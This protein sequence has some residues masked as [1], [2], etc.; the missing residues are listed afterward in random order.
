[1][2]LHTDCIYFFS[3]FQVQEWKNVSNCPC[4]YK[5]RN[6]CRSFILKWPSAL[7]KCKWQM[8]YVMKNTLIKRSNN[9]QSIHCKQGDFTILKELKYLC[10]SR[11]PVPC[12]SV[13]SPWHCPL[14]R[15]RRKPKIPPVRWP[16]GWTTQFTRAYSHFLSFSSVSGET[17]REKWLE[18]NCGKF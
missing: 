13:G 17:T 15:Q 4:L 12:H 14:I 10:V 11:S 8:D 18:N 5:V 7:F 3:N 6:Y 2:V 16:M 1:M 9:H